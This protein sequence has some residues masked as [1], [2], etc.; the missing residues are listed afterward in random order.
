MFLVFA[1][2]PFLQSVNLHTIEFFFP[3][4]LDR[5]ILVTQLLRAHQ[6]PTFLQRP[7]SQTN[8][9]ILHTLFSSE[10][11]NAAVLDYADAA[12]SHNDAI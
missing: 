10:F 3:T 1:N 11:P 7:Q 6:E 12:S 2:S 5:G 4:E 9:F 8:L